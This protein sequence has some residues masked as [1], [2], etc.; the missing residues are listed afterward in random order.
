MMLDPFINRVSALGP[1]IIRSDQHAATGIE[2][3]VL[4]NLITHN[5]N[6]FSM[7]G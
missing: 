7:C 4:D 3:A 2:L 1:F 6:P 5:P